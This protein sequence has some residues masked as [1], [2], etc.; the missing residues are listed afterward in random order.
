MGGGRLK[1]RWFDTIENEIKTSGEYEDNFG[2]QV[3]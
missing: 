2:N 1:Q 3:K